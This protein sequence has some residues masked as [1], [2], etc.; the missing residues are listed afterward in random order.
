MA[1]ALYGKG[2]QRFLKGEINW[3]T[4]DIKAILV[5]AGAYGNI[6]AAINLHEFLTDVP[7][8]SIFATSTSLTGKTTDLGAADAADIEFSSV[9][10]PTLEAIIIYQD[11][12]TPA[13]SPLIAWLDSG[14][15]LPI[16]PNGG[17]IIVTWDNG[18]NKIF[19]L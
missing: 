15:G 9:T 17:N 3:E 4:D 13:T 1:S 7:P 19:R 11:T 5:D 2:R 18:I 10:G 8:S 12:G 16:T 6:S 14:T